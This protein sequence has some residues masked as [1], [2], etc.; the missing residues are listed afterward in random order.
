LLL[1]VKEKVET[2]LREDLGTLS[3]E[4][5]AVLSLLQSRISLT[6]TDKLEASLKAA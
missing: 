5:A 1:E 6:L 4:E 2:E 3:P